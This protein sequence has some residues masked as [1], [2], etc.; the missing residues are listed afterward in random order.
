MKNGRKKSKA[1][2]SYLDQGLLLA[3]IFLMGLGVVQVYS[4]SYIFAI[5]QYEDGL[6]F[7]RKQAVYALL[8]VVALGLGYWIPWSFLKKWGWGLWALAL[9]GIGL[10]LVPE[11]A[12]KSGGAARWLKMPFGMRFE[13]AELLKLSF[14]FVTAGFLCMRPETLREWR[15]WVWL[16]VSVVPFILLLRQPDF[17]SVVICATVLITT[18][19]VYGLSWR[20]LLGAALACVPAFYFLVWNVGYRKARIMTFLDPWS[21]PAKKGFQVIQSMLSFHTGGVWGA[22]LGQGQGKLFFLPEAHTDFI[23]SVF[24]EEMGFIGI[25]FVLTLYGFVVFKGF[26][27]SIRLQD[28]FAQAVALGI[29][30]TLALSIFVNVGVVMGLLPTKGLTLP[31]MS[32]GGSSLLSTCFAC[33]ILLNLGSEG[34]RVVNSKRPHF[35]GIRI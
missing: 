29:T 4:S 21:D 18:L 30:M 14:P 15:P 3:I 17:G 7:V 31:L 13:P 9:I 6:F 1:A 23:F 22:G 28:R 26:Q 24:G 27:F 32:Y 35:R 5:E 11:L 10:T 8:G 25:L 16:A 2:E 20:Y 19:F 34:A 12:I 33:G